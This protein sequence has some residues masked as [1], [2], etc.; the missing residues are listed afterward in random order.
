MFLEARRVRAKP[1]G[2]APLESPIPLQLSKGNRIR[3]QR[4]TLDLLGLCGPLR[5]QASLLN[6]RRSTIFTFRSSY[7]DHAPQRG[8]SKEQPLRTARVPRF[9]A[10]V[11][12]LSL[13]T[14]VGV[15]PALAMAGQ[16]SE[17]PVP[18]GFP[19]TPSVP[20]NAMA[21]GSDGN[22]WFNEDSAHAVGR[23]LT[24]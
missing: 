23:I 6:E 14:L 10:S 19:G 3:Q 24:H 22:I 8:G 20:G 21:L 9:G 11:L 12:L 16:V 5:S 18:Q 15:T 2:L 7:D 4:G 1:P 17:F 13:L